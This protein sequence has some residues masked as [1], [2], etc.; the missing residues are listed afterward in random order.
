MCG[1]FGDP[2]GPARIIRAELV[3][4]SDP[5][6][7]PEYFGCAGS[8]RLGARHRGTSGG[9]RRYMARATESV[10]V[11]FD[12]HATARCSSP[13]RYVACGR[14]VVGLVAVASLVGGHE[15]LDGVVGIASPRDEVIDLRAPAA[16]RTCRWP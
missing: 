9:N 7:L 2:G 14:E 16:R 3:L 4:Q 1:L 12:A 8:N 11:A 13:V 15:V 10:R 6:S 5:E